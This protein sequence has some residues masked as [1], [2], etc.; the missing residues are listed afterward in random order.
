MATIRQFLHSITTL[1]SSVSIKLFMIIRTSISTCLFPQ[2][3][4]T[5]ARAS[6]SRRGV[7]TLEYVLMAAVGIGA[8]VLVDKFFLGNG[9]FISKITKNVGDMFGGG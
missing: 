9:G 7:G 6:K 2:P 5:Y 4:P 8:Y 1:I 3:R